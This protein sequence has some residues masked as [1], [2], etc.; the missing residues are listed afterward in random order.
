[1][2]SRPCVVLT[3]EPRDNAPLARALGARGVPV[4]EL[5]CAATRLLPAAAPTSAPA[6]VAFASRRGVEGFLAAGLAPLLD[7]R[8]GALVAAV[9]PA[10]A[11]ALEAAGIEVSM[12]AEPATGE[13]LAEALDARLPAGVAV[14]LPRGR[15]PGRLDAALAAL[16][17]AVEVVEVYDNPT[18]ELP[19]LPPF[20]VAAVFVAAPSAAERL[21]A[22]LPWMIDRPF[23][24]IGPTT[25]EALER[26]GVAEI[27]GQ[28]AV[29]E[30]QVRLLEDAWRRAVASDSSPFQR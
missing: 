26:L 10:T 27:L 12:V 8:S 1:M 30:E 16:G 29:H 5:P 23:L 24:A 19:E 13:A 25:L 18:P 2:P 28:S 3:R 7:A 11:E 6:A 14:L 15:L 4:R 17:R 9:G 20:P 21:L 22:R